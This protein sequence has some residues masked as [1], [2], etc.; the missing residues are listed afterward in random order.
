MGINDNPRNAVERYG[1]L[2]EYA[3]ERTVSLPRAE[4]MR[5]RYRIG[6]PTAATSSRQLL[7]GPGDLTSARSPAGSRTS[8]SSTASRGR[9]RD[10]T[11]A[12]LWRAFLED[13]PITG[14][15]ATR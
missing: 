1:P 14:L 7:A 15:E 12:P 3:F 13:C 2:P 10:G 5:I 4:G 9:G 6:R 11:V 8:P